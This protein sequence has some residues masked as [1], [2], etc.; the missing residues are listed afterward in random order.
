MKT[1]KQNSNQNS[2]QVLNKQLHPMRI[3]YR[4]PHD[5]KQ[6]CKDDL[7]II[8]SWMKF[9]IK[10]GKTLVY[11]AAGNRI[12]DEYKN[13]FYDNVILVD[14]N[15]RGCTYD[16][17]KI[18]CLSLDAIVAVYILKQLNVKIDC[19]VCI[20]EGLYEGNGKYSINSNYFLN[21]CFPLFADTVL[22]MANNKE[23]YAGSEY[24]NIRAHYLELPFIKKRRVT[25][26]DDEYISP[27]I[28]SPNE[29]H[30]AEVYLF[31]DKLDFKSSF[32][33]G[34]TP[35]HVHQDSIWNFEEELDIIYIGF[36]NNYQKAIYEK[37]ETK[38]ID[39]ANFQKINL[40]GCI[41][42]KNMIH[43]FISDKKIKKVGIMTNGSY[44]IDI[45]NFLKI[46]IHKD[47]EEIHFFH[48]ENDNNEISVEDY[49]L[50]MLCC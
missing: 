1:N 23:Y 22:Y 13:L 3:N 47:L 33:C 43:A 14:Y 8:I 18:F 17:E 25:P 4:K 20:C 36:E 42:D 11:F 19:F 39:T 50:Q 2:N 46:E 7:S 26:E 24:K 41:N 32:N 48:L 10:P 34:E 29:G 15:F 12:D 49:N 35:I 6:F 28:F 44:Y 45:I 9:F 27:L 40:R 31:E 37:L 38:I 5:I 30:K 16:G 21:Y